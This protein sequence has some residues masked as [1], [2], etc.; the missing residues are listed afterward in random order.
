MQYI[1]KNDKDE[2]ITLDFPIGTAPEKKTINGVKYVRNLEAEFQSKSFSLK[3]GGWPTQDVKRKTQMTNNNKAAGKRTKDTW[4]EAKKA[5]PN[6]KGKECGTWK[7]A[8]DL[9]SKNKE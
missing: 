4:G 8:A 2:N 9:A 7:E 6:Y 3:G 1:Y 5:I